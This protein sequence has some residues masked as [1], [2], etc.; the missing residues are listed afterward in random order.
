MKLNHEVIGASWN[1]NDALWEVQVR[2]LKTKDVFVDRAEIFINGGGVLKYLDSCS[3]TCRA[4]LIKNSNWKWPDIEGLHDFQGTLCHTANYPARTILDGKRVAVIGVGSSGI[5]V[6][7]NIASKVS[8]LYTWVRSPTWITAG[9]A[10]KYAGPNG[11]NFRCEFSLFD[12]ITPTDCLLDTEQQQQGF[13]TDFEDYVQYTKNIEDELN[14]R[15]KFILNG[16]PEAREAK[17]VRGSKWLTSSTLIHM[18]CS[19][20]PSRCERSSVDER[21]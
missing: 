20:R 3:L 5:Q 18:S 21:T 2:N 8:K 11:G 14:Q 10:Q 17:E 9:F 19:S 16:T 13:A 15:F 6:T 4:Q 12:M 7:A 1:D